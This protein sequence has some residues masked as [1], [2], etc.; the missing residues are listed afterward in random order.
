MELMW[1]PGR[2]GGMRQ[3]GGL[4]ASLRLGRVVP[5]RRGATAA[6]P[7]AEVLATWLCH[8]DYSSPFELYDKESA[9]CM[10]W[11]CG[12]GGGISPLTAAMRFGIRLGC[13]LGRL[14]MLNVK[15]HVLST[16][17]FSLVLKVVP[18]ARGTEGHSNAC[19]HSGCLAPASP[20]KTVQ[21]KL[22]AYWVRPFSL[23]LLR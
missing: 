15:L 18:N 12:S 17:V 22:Y 20:V 11:P 14:A 4:R 23:G 7:R 1:P 8:A 9:T 13:S 5:W 6:F 16:V 10:R 19:T 21:L 2:G 3:D